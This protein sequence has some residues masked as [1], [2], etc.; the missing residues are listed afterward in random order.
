MKNVQS[1]VNKQQLSSIFGMVTYS[2][3]YMQDISDVAAY[4]RG[5]MK[6]DALFQWTELYDVAFQKIKEYIRDIY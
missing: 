3:C 2:S 4:C 1:P 5:F 6:K